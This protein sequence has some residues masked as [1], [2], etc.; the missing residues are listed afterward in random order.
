MAVSDTQK[1]DLLYKKL[2][3]VAKTDLATN[4]SASGEP[5]ASPLILRGDTVWA[6]SDN[7]PGTAA[8]V[9]DIVQAYL[10]T[11]R[12]ECTA[13]TS[14]TPIGGVYPTWKTNLTDWIPPEFGS[15]YF[16]SVYA[17]TTGTAN[18]TTTTPLSDSGISGVGE[19]YFDYSAGILNFIG[20]TIPATLTGAKKLFIT[21]YR[22]IGL[23]GL[24][25]TLFGH[26]ST[27]NVALLANVANVALIANVATIANV[28]VLAN[29]ALIANVAT[30]ANVAVLANVATIANVAVTANAL[31]VA[32]TITLGGDVSGSV[33]FDGS[34][35][36]TI[37]AT[38]AADS[39][40]LGTDTTG[41]YVSSITS[42][43]GIGVATGTGEGSVPTI[44]NTGVVSLAGTAN[45][46]SV[47]SSNG[48]VI[49]GLPNDVT[50]NNNLTVEGNLFVRGTA[51]TLNT[52]SVTLNDSLVRFG[53]ANPANSLDIGFY[54]EFV[55]GATTKYT[56][57][58]RDHID[59]NYRLF[60]DSTVNPTGNTISTADS[61]YTIASLVANLTG[62][63]VSGLTANIN[64]GD[65]GTGRGTF[66]TNGILYG[67]ATGALNVTAAGTFG[68]VLAV[69]VN[70]L[71]VFG[72][73]DCGTF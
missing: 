52:A 38:I 32:R 43:T 44:T 40:A 10:T 48:S 68:Q 53:N 64:V 9:T 24:S 63:T 45:Q 25:T 71:P 5:N 28:A 56:G 15:T 1:V 35:N 66:T 30:I 8:A 69:D 34:S 20:G 11:S 46:V 31:T 2:F 36:V 33:S 4:K 58:F 16:I 23:K 17:D 29:V 60:R 7:I 67:N 57:L 42:G 49:V 51:V 59:G 61:G 12:I 62:G 14:S 37:T 72:R 70:G 27:A 55:S 65:G 39:V 26:S 50:V 22:Y 3:G 6:Q 54:G 73:L 13:D 41:D 21:G 18:P 19:W 47:N